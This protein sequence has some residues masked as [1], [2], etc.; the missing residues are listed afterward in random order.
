LLDGLLTTLRPKTP[1]G[2]SKLILCVLEQSAHGDHSW[3]RRALK[4]AAAALAE[5]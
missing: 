4:N 1:A 3:H 2:A 5:I